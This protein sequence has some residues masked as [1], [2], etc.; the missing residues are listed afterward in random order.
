MFTFPR[1]SIS[2]FPMP[3]R[4]SDQIPG[5][6]NR[7]LKNE[8]FFFSNF[9]MVANGWGFVGSSFGP[10]FEGEIFDFLIFIEFLK[11]A[12]RKAKQC[13]ICAPLLEEKAL[14]LCSP[15]CQVIFSE[16]LKKKIFKKITDKIVSNDFKLSRLGDL[17]RSLAMYV[18]MDS[19][20]AGGIS[21]IPF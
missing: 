10:G 18:P 21:Y 8:E 4:G 17:K 16:F 2:D 9:R 1:G 6:L 15:N 14:F 19:E 13:W 11:F 20:E 3:P 5:I 7:T 12:L